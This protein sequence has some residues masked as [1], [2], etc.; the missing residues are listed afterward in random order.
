MTDC[1]YRVGSCVDNGHHGR[2]DAE[3][4]ASSNSRDGG[5]VELVDEE[6][7][8]NV[9]NPCL[10]Q[11]TLCVGPVTQPKVQMGL[12]SE[13]SKMNRP[14]GFFWVLSPLTVRT[15]PV[16]CTQRSCKEGYGKTAPKKRHKYERSLFEIH[17]LIL[18]LTFGNYNHVF[19]KF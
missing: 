14:I 9:E 4:D 17:V 7:P 13:K 19:T 18:W 11:H 15:D 2:D 3:K 12:V 8:L 5:D 6:L 10:S 16:L 1:F